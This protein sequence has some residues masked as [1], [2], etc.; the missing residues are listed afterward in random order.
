MAVWL[1][2]RD[3][4][5]RLGGF[6]SSVVVPA[7]MEWKGQYSRVIAEC[8]LLMLTAMVGRVFGTVKLS[9]HRFEASLADIE[10]QARRLT[11]VR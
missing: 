8:R 9:A 5:R 1:V 2:R 10:S 4:A 7:L 6:T 11:A 3:P